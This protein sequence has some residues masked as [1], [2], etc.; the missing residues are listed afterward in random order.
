MVVRRKWIELHMIFIL[1]TMLLV[2]CTATEPRRTCSNWTNLTWTGGRIIGRAAYTPI[3]L[4]AP[5]GL[6]G[7]G[8]S[9]TYSPSTFAEAIEKENQPPLP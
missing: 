1:T 2:S 6:E 8:S 9:L 4:C 5:G 3:T 7:E